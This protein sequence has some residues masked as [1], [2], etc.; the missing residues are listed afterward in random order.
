MLVNEFENED[1]SPKHPNLVLYFTTA[2]KLSV[3]RKKALERN[4]NLGEF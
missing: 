4:P 3:Q 1:G 2:Q